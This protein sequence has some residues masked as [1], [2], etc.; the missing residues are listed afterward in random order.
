MVFFYFDTS[1]KWI[2]FNFADV[3]E[4][5]FFDCIWA[6]RIEGMENEWVAVLLVSGV[7]TVMVTLTICVKKQRDKIRHI[8]GTREEY[9]SIIMVLKD[10]LWK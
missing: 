3:Y 2:W 4:R 10:R 1:R 7:F 5:V 9:K 6:I 8:R